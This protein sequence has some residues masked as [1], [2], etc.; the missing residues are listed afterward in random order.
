MPLTGMIDA[1]LAVGPVEHEVVA[2]LEVRRLA[3]VLRA[4]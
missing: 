2:D 3:V 4:G 1:L